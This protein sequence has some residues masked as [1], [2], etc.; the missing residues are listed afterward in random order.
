MKTGSELYESLL[1]EFQ[2]NFKK[3]SPSFGNLLWQLII[4]QAWQDN[5]IHCFVPVYDNNGLVLGIAE[6]N[7]A[8]YFNTHV[9]FNK[10][11]TFDK[12]SNLLEI[13]NEQIFGLQK[14]AT[15]NVILSS[16]K[17]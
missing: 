17:K 15:G 13:L 7:V 5:N 6:N 11:F 14:L 2:D 12:A 1:D 8:G 4:N 3:S 10:E 9:Y 16:M